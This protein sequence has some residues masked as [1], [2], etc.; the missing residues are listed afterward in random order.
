MH[1]NQPC[2]PRQATKRLGGGP[3]SLEGR[4]LHCS[5]G[6]EPCWLVACKENSILSLSCEPVPH[7]ECV[8]WCPGNP[9]TTHG[10]KQPTGRLLLQKWSCRTSQ[11]APYLSGEG[12]ACTVLL[13]W[14]PASCIPL[15]A[16]VCRL[17]PILK[18]KNG[19]NTNYTTN[20]STRHKTT[21]P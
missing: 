18:I 11:C 4:K 9:T 1:R 16:S 10:D 3:Q 13:E 21:S 19:F 7:S 8:V 6:T 5:Q 14:D 17:H 12:A 2:Q 20:S 15:P